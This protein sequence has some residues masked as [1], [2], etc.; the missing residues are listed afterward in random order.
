MIDSVSGKAHLQFVAIKRKDS[1]EWALPGV[2]FC[3]FLKIISKN[4]T[5]YEILI[6]QF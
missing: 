6:K 4:H 3:E 1:G 5:S 2:C